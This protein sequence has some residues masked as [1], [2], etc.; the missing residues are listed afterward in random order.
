MLM[1]F[2]ALRE[3][4][5]LL[6]SCAGFSISKKISLRADGLIRILEIRNKMNTE[7]NDE[8]VLKEK[9]S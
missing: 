4:G 9:R 3:A 1:T 6:T 2:C 8:I 5:N 7:E